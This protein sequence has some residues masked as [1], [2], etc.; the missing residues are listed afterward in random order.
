MEIKKENSFKATCSSRI[1]N[2]TSLCQSTIRVSNKD[3]TRFT[4]NSRIS[5]EKGIKTRLTENKEKRLGFSMETKGQV[6]V[7]Q[8][9]KYLQVLE[10]TPSLPTSS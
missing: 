1:T 9:L 8:G 2:G 3:L 7:L 10:S 5:E 4:N 6:L